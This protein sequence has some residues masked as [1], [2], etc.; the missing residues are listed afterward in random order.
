MSKPD[1]FP[2]H[3]ACFILS[4]ALAVH[5]D[6]TSKSPYPGQPLLLSLPVLDL[7][8]SLDGG[9]SSPSMQQT[10]RWSAGSRQAANQSI[11]WAWEGMR[12]SL[13]RTAGTWAS[14]TA[15]RYVSPYL[16][17]GP[18]W[19]HEEGHRAVL[20]IHGHSSFNGVYHWEFGGSTVAVDGV[21]DRDL[22]SLKDSHP[23]DFTRLM[24]AGYEMETETSLLMRRTD[25]FLGRSSRYDLV[26]HWATGLGATLYLFVCSNDA[27]DKEI[28]EANRR[29]TSESK[30]DFTGLDYRAWV[31]DLRHPDEKYAQGP[32]GQ[33]HPSGSGFDR[34]LLSTDLTA[35]EKEI[36]RLQAGLSLLNFVS[37]QLFGWNRLTGRNPFT[38]S[39]LA[40][41]FAVVHQLTPFG[42]SLGG[43]ALF[44]QGFQSWRLCAR[45]QV[46]ER[47]ILPYLAGELWRY[48]VTAGQH[49]LL[50]TVGTSAWLQPK[51][52]RYSSASVEP[53]AA[54]L[55]GVAQPLGKTFELLGEM[56]AKSK[57]WIPGN[58]YL[59][60]A[61]Q[62]RAGIQARL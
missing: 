25:F 47:R 3:F 27:L 19:L 55:L 61:F 6:I 52:Q 59:G 8:Y 41:N 46:G 33:V 28:A 48:P 4:F 5:S 35:K 23:P 57:G 37:P 31:Y 1:L 36:L 13:L 21:A 51:D 56:D 38:G 7:P 43:D 53:G 30:R 22:A 60:A 12:P 18:T 10:V 11:G 34:Y 42:Y 45:A 50:A 15:F 32:R 26:D 40:W 2:P 9:I 17:L 29:E 16:P 49:P 14:L 54:L 20:T 44:S 39:P 58:A 62:V 24:E